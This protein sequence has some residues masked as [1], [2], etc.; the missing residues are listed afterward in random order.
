VF[1]RFCFKISLKGLIRLISFVLL[2]TVCAGCH[3]KHLTARS[4]AIDCE[5]LASFYVNT[6]DPR[7][8]G[9]FC[10]QQIV[11]EWNLPNSDWHRPDLNLVLSMITT[12]HRFDKVTVPL[13]SRFGNY[14]YRL[15][16]ECLCEKGA[17]LTYKAEIYSGNNLLQCWQ[18]QGWVDWIPSN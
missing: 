6:P 14:I 10:G 5:Y 3:R 13:R 11:V 8:N 15:T 16:N 18:Q 7:N 1:K 17:V 9:N 4:E 12:N 2:M